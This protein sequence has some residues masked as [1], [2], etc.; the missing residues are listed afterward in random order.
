MAKFDYKGAIDEGYS[1]EEIKSFLSQHKKN[2]YEKPK[3]NDGFFSKIAKNARNFGRNFLNPTGEVEIEE[4]QEQE[5]QINEKLLKKVPNFDYQAAINE[6]YSSDE[7]NDFLQQNIQEKSIPEK[8]GRT[9]LQY[10][11]GAAENALLPYE[12][13]AASLSSKEAQNIPYRE[14]LSEDLENLMNK[15]AAG[16]WTE[17]DQQEYD[18]ITKQIED[19]QESIKHAKNLNVGVRDAI[20]NVTGVDLEPEGV[21]EKAAHWAGFIRNPKNLAQLSKSGIK[22]SQLMKAIAPT[23]GEVLRGAGAGIAME[24]AEQGQFGPIGNMAA[25]V[26][27]DILGHGV[28]G[29]LKGAGQLIRNP[30]KTIAKLATN[31]TQKEK[32]KLQ[33]EII[34]EFRDVGIQADLGSITDSSLVKWTQSKI[35][36]SGL[37][38]DAFEKLKKNITNDVVKSYQDISNTLGEYR[39]ANIHEAGEVAKKGMENIRDADLG[40]TREFYKNADRSLKRNP[41][42]DPSRVVNTIKRIEK[43]LTPG[44]VKSPQ[45]ESVL[46]VLND[47]K[48]DVMDRNGNAIYANVKNLM[49]NKI[50]LND[51]INYEIQGGT[52]QLLKQIIPDLDRVIIDHGIENPSFSRNYI[53]A[54]KRFSEHAKTFRNKE[55]LNLLKASDPTQIFN[56][57]NSVQGMKNIE[58]IL[59]RT[60]EGKKLYGDLKKLK[61]DQILHSNLVDST[62]QQVKFGTFSKIL[63]K[64]K[65][66]DLVK[67]MLG[68]KAFSQ[69]EKLQRSTGR[70]ANSYNKFFNPSKSGVVA[71]DMAVYAK[72]MNDISQIIAGNPWPLIKTVGTVISTTK[73]SKLLTDPE[74]LKLTEEYILASGKNDFIKMTSSLQKLKPYLNQIMKKQKDTPQI[75][76][77]EQ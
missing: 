39:F 76:E 28:S 65:N 31:F 70:L 77:T 32:L 2:L 21:L 30:K 68:I 63:E 42:V 6:G 12:I 10:A 56:K 11:T 69:L 43:E 19:P 58:K 22:L 53:E 18:N 52:K 44:Q 61:L 27:G 38:G 35:E 3:E 67:E 24:M 26:I 20:E 55:V 50:A 33:K 75:E 16:Q 13:G 49:N 34:Q 60:G 14:S 62:T 72:G 4:E 45:Q 59:S 46:K 7:I 29:T 51:I 40:A 17:E 5:Q 54:N 71:V 41:I 1:P 66:R 47:L 9:A 8:I 64:G 23:G 57:M 48:R 15:K 25:T 36:Q 37:T 74:F 73:L